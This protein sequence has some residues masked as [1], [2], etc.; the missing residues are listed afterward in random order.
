[1]MKRSAE[2]SRCGEYRY[3]LWREWDKDK[4]VAMCI[5]LNPSTAN[6]EKDDP[7]IT[8]LIG[9][10]TQLGFGTLY[11]CNLYALISS[12][13]ARLFEVA[14]ALGN[15]DEW[16]TRTSKYVNEIIFCWGAFKNID[17]RS[18]VVAAMFPQ[19]KC[20]GKSK[21]GRPL[22]PLALMYAGVKREDVKLFSYG[23]I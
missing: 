20:F 6:A 18:K 14:D 15:N 13:P 9:D 5:G 19:G 22:H 21:D 7:T 8:R 10:L 2:F 3:L 11:M 16:L 1:M 17:Y 12:K 23:K 4:P